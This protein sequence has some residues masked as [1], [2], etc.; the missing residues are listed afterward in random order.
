MARAVR[1][2]GKRSAV[3]DLGLQN[4]EIDDSLLGVGLYAVPEAARII[5][6]SLGTHVSETNLR[7]W[8]VGRHTA[9]RDYSPILQAQLRINDSYLF[10]FEDL[11]E[12]ITVGELRNRGMKMSAV[13]LAYENAEQQFGK[14]PF[15]KRQYSAHGNKLFERKTAYGGAMQ[16]LVTLQHAF[17]QVIKPLLRHIVVYV[18][19]IPTQLTPLGQD[20]SVILDPSRAFGSPINRESGVVTSS[21]YQMHKAG[22]SKERIANWFQI[23]VAGVSDAIEYES[24]LVEAA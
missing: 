4:N 16:D 22:E 2:S 5:S 15:A 13:R 12:L 11:I 24:G 20:R 17:E 1:Q 6:F 14:R 3:R 21:L 10:T 9:K 23:S 8:T 7:R 18:G 19:N